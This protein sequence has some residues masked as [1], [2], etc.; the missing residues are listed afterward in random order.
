VWQLLLPMALMGIAN[1]FM[2]A[3]LA[4]TATRNLPLSSAGAGSGIYNTTRQVG[5]V[6]GSAAIAALIQARLTANLPGIPQGATPHAGTPLPPQI[7]E[8]FATAM[9]EALLLPAAVL[10]VAV[11]A[12]L[13]FERPRHQ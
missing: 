5:A 3:P 10:L 11:V 4:A 2:W 1:A 12:A 7:A 8:G 13:A 6:L 9:S